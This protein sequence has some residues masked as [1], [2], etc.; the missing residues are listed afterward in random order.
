[1]E[2]VENVAGE[3]RKAAHSQMAAT[4]QRTIR[5]AII[6]LPCLHLWLVYW[7]CWERNHSGLL[8]VR[9][10]KDLCCPTWI[11]SLSMWVWGVRSASCLPSVQQ[12]TVNIYFIFCAAQGECQHL[13]PAGSAHREGHQPDQRERQAGSAGAPEQDQGLAAGGRDREV[14]QAKCLQVWWRIW[15]RICYDI[16]IC[17]QGKKW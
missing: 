12:L 3:F 5:S 6:R 9:T 8:L 13:L 15:P 14:V 17:Y 7:L 11:N 2:R 1:M 4:T 10:Q 16:L